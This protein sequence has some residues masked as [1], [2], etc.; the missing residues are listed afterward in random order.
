MGTS[1]NNAVPNVVNGR[2]V[3]YREQAAGAYRSIT[4]LIGIL[5]TEIPI[6]LLTSLL[7]STITYWLAG[8]APA[9]S[10]FFFFA[11]IV[12]IYG[13]L[14]MTFVIF[15]SFATP[16]GEIAQGLVGVFTSV[17]SLFAGF[18][19]TRPN[20]PKYWIWM[21]YLNLVHYPLE[22]VVVNEME[23][24]WFGCPHGKGAVEV[25]IPSANTTK[26]YCPITTGEMMLESVDY[27]VGNKFPDMAITLAFWFA[28][29]IF[30]FLALRFIR[31]IKR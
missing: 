18:I 23:G 4:F 17:F 5:V 1:A 31:H 7:I 29:V 22:A 3:F 20:I 30:S 2:S 24:N 28:F 12:F 6:T 15:L 27:K 16:N 8:L 9:A 25:Y 13:S 19:I 11:W 14:T 21:Y 26:E 10:H